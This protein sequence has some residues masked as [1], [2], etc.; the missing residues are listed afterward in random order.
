MKTNLQKS[1]LVLAMSAC[2]LL[3]SPVTANQIDVDAKGWKLVWSD[4]FD[5]SEIDTSKWEWE[6]NCW[7]GGNNE[8]QCY[9][10]R[11]KNSFVED[12]KLII[13]AFKETYIG[14]AE[15]PEVNP[16]AGSK[17]LPYTSA[18]LRTLNKGDWTYGRF[19]IRAKVPA[20]QGL[21]PAIWM[22]PSE[23][24][25][26]AWAASGEIDI[27]EAVSMPPESPN[28]EIHGTIHY[29][30]EWPAN[31]NTGEKYVFESSD[32]SKDFHTY[33]IEW[34]D[35]EIRWYVDDVHFATQTADGWYS[36][37]KNEEGIKYDV[38]GSAP[39]D[40]PFH[41]LL[42]LAVGGNW[43]GAPDAS[44]VFPAQMEVDYVRVYECPTAKSSLNTC[45]TKSRDAKRNFGKQPPKLINVDY[46]PGF[47][48]ADIVDVYVDEAVPPFA[49][50]N[51]SASGSVK[52]EEVPVDG[53]GNVAQFTFGSNESVVYLQAAK[54]FDFSAFSSMSF[55]LRVLTDPRDSGGMVMKVD[56][57]FPCG[58][59]DIPLEAAPVGDWTTYSYTMGDL[60][61]HPGSTL[62]AKNID[63]PLVIFPTWGQQ[64]GV[65][66]QI[67][68][69]RYMR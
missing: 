37:A 40:Q 1:K 17:T 11:E 4:E 6:S 23:W 15:P 35:G 58:T 46:D 12:G 21:W 47:I 52:I 20:G 32:P 13:R 64:E 41:L 54:G 53:R 29:G 7:G 25:Y 2:A 63:T 45:A 50:G 42:N 36:Q 44:T 27:M 48:D 26:G 5:G 65:V 14:R 62:N 66:F 28:K 51:Y 24:R 60:R 3:S 8:L 10:D 49:I 67:D 38:E 33:A 34:A 9:T 30:A 16:N 22:L 18:R 69:V 59:G 61:A 57:Q 43:P 68:N 19:E 56:C 39:F 31:V 55:D